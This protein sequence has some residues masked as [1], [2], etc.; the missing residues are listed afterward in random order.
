ML[1]IDVRVRM[2]GNIYVS[3]RVTFHSLWTLFTAQGAL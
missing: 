1:D 3:F 2:L